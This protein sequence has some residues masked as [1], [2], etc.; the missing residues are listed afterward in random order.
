L[1]E[2]ES[3]SRQTPLAAAHQWQQRVRNL[4][5]TGE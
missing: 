5:E 3:L 4:P 1:S 2:F